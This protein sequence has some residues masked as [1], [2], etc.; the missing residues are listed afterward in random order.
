MAHYSIRRKTPRIIYYQDYANSL[1]NAIVIKH[2][3]LK[4]QNISIFISY[5]NSLTNVRN[6][7]QG[8]ESLNLKLSFFSAQIYK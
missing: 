6:Y 4:T 8:H 7:P 5:A 2:S 1:T 3:V